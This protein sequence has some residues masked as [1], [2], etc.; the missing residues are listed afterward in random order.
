MM[1]RAKS[2][3]D[4]AATKTT[5]DRAGGQYVPLTHEQVLLKLYSIRDESLAQ[6]ERLCIDGIAKGTGTWQLSA[7]KAIGE[8]IRSENRGVSTGAVTITIAGFDPAQ[9][10]TEEGTS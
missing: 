4:K 8:I 10:E 7:E 6:W 1:A 5:D 9:I 3:A 2:K